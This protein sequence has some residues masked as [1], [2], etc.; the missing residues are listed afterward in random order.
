MSSYWLLC[1]L[2]FSITTSALALSGPR[3]MIVAAIAYRALSPQ[4]RLQ[5]AGILKKHDCAAKWMAEVPKNDAPL[6][7]GVMFMMG[8]AK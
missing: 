7:E 3:D 5:V 1:T 6:D 2:L 4:E 8:A